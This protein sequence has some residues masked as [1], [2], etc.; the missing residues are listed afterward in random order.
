[1]SMLRP[2][3]VIYLSLSNSSFVF[4][5][6]NEKQ[7]WHSVSSY[8]YEIEVLQSTDELR[9]NSVIDVSGTELRR[10]KS[11]Y[12]RDRNHLFIKHFVCKTNGVWELKKSAAQ[13]YE[14]SKIRFCDIFAGQAP[15]FQRSDMPK[16]PPKKGG[17]GNGTPVKSPSKSSATGGKIK[18]QE[19]IDKYLKPKTGDKDR[20]PSKTA[21]ANA[22]ADK[23]GKDSAS[24]SR[25]KL[26]SNKKAEKRKSTEEILEQELLEKRKK[27]IEHQQQLIEKKQQKQLD[28]LRKR[29]EK[30]KL[31]EFMKEWNKTRE[32]LELEDLKEL[33]VPVPVCLDGIPNNNFGQL[34]ML[35]EFFHTF[36]DQLNLKT[37]FPAGVTIDLLDRALSKAEL[38]GPLF[39][40]IHLL[41][42]A[43]FRS[44]EEEEDEIGETYDSFAVS[45]FENLDVGTV[46]NIDSS[47]FSPSSAV[48]SSTLAETNVAAVVLNW[49][50]VFHGVP[51]YKMTIDATTVTEILRLHL[52]SSG[53]RVSETCNRWRMQEKGG[54]VSSDDPGLAFRISNPRIMRLL[55]EKC[56]A[57]L[58]VD[59]KLS[60]LE[61]LVD[62][63]IMFSGFRDIINDCV[64]NYRHKRVELRLALAAEVRKEKELGQKK[65]EKKPEKPDGQPAQIEDAAIEKLEKDILKNKEDLRR[66]LAD[67]TAESMK[68]QL[69]P[70]GSDRAYRRFWLFPSIPGI[71][72]ED[73]EPNPPPCL[74][75]G[76][77]KP[78]I[79]L[80]KE[81][82]QLSYVRKLFETEYNKE[83]LGFVTST[84]SPRKRANIG[85]LSSD[86]AV[87]DE[88]AK[89]EYTCWGDNEKCPVHCRTGDRVRWSFYRTQNDFDNLLNSLNT[90]GKRESKLR[91]IL[92]QQ[93]DIILKSMLRP[94]VSLN[95]TIS[96]DDENSAIAEIRKSSRGNPTYENA[97]FDFPAD[98][99]VENV[100]ESLL[101]NVILDI[102]EKSNAGGLGCLR[103]SIDQF[104]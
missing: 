86:Q 80:M 42:A 10:K 41:L 35:Y 75:R 39:D 33:P 65:K 30:K 78:N 44:Q 28:I 13:R 3:M 6:S 50:L 1:M 87:K 24:G 54:Y 68:V 14:I 38:A 88:I 8:V 101:R 76:T 93:K 31:E 63:V 29:D 97:M 40:F 99:D 12:T 61:C 85:A 26:Q 45:E 51:L 22:G 9:K 79:A 5:R 4:C 43:I 69:T 49:P 89:T 82:D 53:C 66:Q 20:K 17:P 72:V 59:D 56:V 32:D 19:S 46:C 74:P 21:P 102:E 23:K 16:K 67:L 58:S 96:M 103:V 84:G 91:S 64:E 77:P 36:A 37:F 55:S 100:M 62:Q 94:F 47:S 71:F 52:L 83:N 11:T 95:K 15:K 90:R 34:V 92:I 60:I 7:F 27:M 98:T 2:S 81:K 25:S 73:N 48:S 18:K 57:A 104:C 70:I